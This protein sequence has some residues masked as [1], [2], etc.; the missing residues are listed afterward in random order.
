MTKLNC[1]YCFEEIPLYD[2][3]GKRRDGNRL[4]HK[5]CAY[6]KKLERNCLN[7]SKIKQ[8][9]HELRKTDAVLAKLYK[10]QEEKVEISEYLALSL[11]LKLNVIT[12]LKR[13]KSNNQKVGLLIDYAFQVVTVKVSENKTK[14]ILIKIYKKDECY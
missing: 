13:L 10:L 11:G 9:M 6:L 14:G 1:K 7:Y 4:Y 8:S 12:K 2:E 3:Y 5:E